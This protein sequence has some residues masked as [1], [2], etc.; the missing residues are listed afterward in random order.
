[1]DLCISINYTYH[2]LSRWNRA[3][4]FCLSATT[5]TTT[6]TTTL[7]FFEFIG[8]DLERSRD[9]IF[10]AKQTERV[11]CLFS[12]NW[13]NFR[14]VL[15]QVFGLFIIHSTFKRESSNW[16]VK[17][18]ATSTYCT[19]FQTILAIRQAGRQAGNPLFSLI[20]RALNRVSHSR[21]HQTFSSL[22]IYDI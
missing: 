16:H 7:V 4:Y 14:K 3:I 10:I 2:K 11:E 5:T 17:S 9:I 20:K 8:T 19:R 6:T 1:M 13:Q 12:V 21:E 22:S 18:S 15:S